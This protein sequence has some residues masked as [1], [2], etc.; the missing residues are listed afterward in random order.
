[1]ISQIIKKIIGYFCYYSGILHLYAALKSLF[2][3]REVAVL[4]YHR[5]VGEE[6]TG[7]PN[8]VNVKLHR[9]R[10]HI[11]YLSTKYHIISFAEL[12]ALCN[13]SGSIPKR[14]VIITFDDGYE[15]NYRLAYPILRDNNATATIALTTGCIG[16]KEMFWWDKVAHSI[17]NTNVASISHKNLGT[18]SLQNRERATRMVQARLKKLRDDVKNQTLLDIL[19]QLQVPIPE[20]RNRFLTWE[21]IVEMSN[22][23]IS[24]AVHTV[25]HPILT[26]I[27]FNDAKREIIE[28]RKEIESKIGRKITVF[29]YPNGGA[30]DMSEEIDDFLIKEGFHFILTT[31]YGTNRINP[32]I[33]FINRIGIEHD[34]DLVLFKLKLHAFGKLFSSLYEK[35]KALA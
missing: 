4:M 12:Q 32:N 13:Q 6:H 1:M 2:G 33:V 27:S 3:V 23:N 11:E 29:A 14:S 24:F 19:K 9:F 28:S 35:L 25:N 22:N 8:I 34:D 7:E 21:Q 20:V 10:S 15:D 18:I 16:G 26:R 30:E 17:S 31:R 5:I